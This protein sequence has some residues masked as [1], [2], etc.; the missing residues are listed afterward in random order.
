M[1]CPICATQVAPIETQC[2]KC[3]SN[4]TEY[5]Q[6]YYMPDRLFNEALSRMRHKRYAEAAEKLCCAAGL[7]PDDR[8]ILLAWAE[9][10]ALS[11]DHAAAV[12]VLEKALDYFSDDDAVVDM[13]QRENALAEEV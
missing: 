7:R 3:G 5:S 4:L 1:K 12:R 6:V 10:C 8:D 11:G 13:F 2:P 9:C